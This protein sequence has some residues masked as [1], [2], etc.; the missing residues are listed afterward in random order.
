MK[1][2]YATWEI[3]VRRPRS[4]IYG[5]S[6]ASSGDGHAGQDERGSAVFDTPAGGGREEPTAAESH[7]AQATPENGRLIFILS[8]CYYY[9]GVQ[10]NQ[11]LQI[12]RYRIFVLMKISYI[13]VVTKKFFL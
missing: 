12:F 1:I 6:P 7:Q 11:L 8:Y 5:E 3:V 2:L 13:S 10:Q 4:N 9:L